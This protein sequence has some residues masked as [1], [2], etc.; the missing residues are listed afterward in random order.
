MQQASRNLGLPNWSLLNVAVI[1][2][3][4][5]SSRSFSPVARIGIHI[6]GTYDLRIPGDILEL[7]ASLISAEWV[8]PACSYGF[9]GV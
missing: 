9:L 2:D 3:A 6:V 1:G 7:Q 8:D 4:N 5:T